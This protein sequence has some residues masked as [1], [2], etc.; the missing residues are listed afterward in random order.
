KRLMH[1]SLTASNIGFD[2]SWLDFGSM[3]AVSDY[4][5]LILPRGA[6]DFLNEERTIYQA[7]RD[8]VF[9]INKYIDA[10]A[11]S[12]PLAADKYCSVLKDAL[13]AH[14]DL[15]FEKLTGLPHE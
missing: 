5:R 14:E 8:L 11:R 4:G 2:G 6:P 7:L 10:G 12:K 1:G 3:S 15:E 13:S 9:Y